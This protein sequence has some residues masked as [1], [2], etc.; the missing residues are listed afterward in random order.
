MKEEKPRARLL[1]AGGAEVIRDE[2][3]KKGTSL[4][5]ERSF[6]KGNNPHLGVVRCDTK[7]D[8]AERPK[9]KGLSEVVDDRPRGTLA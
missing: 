2:P 9:R 4:R 3:Q 5:V 1:Y 8:G 7:V 6:E